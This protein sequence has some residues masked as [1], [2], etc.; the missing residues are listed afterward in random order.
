MC[1][2]M[3]RKQVKPLLDKADLETV[4]RVGRALDE[5]N[6]A[7]QSLHEARQQPGEKA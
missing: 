4:A 6:Q 2:E 1:I 5:I 7:S 3:A